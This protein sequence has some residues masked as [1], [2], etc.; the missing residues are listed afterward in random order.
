MLTKQ[1]CLP[2]AT[3]GVNNV[4]LDYEAQ[5]ARR[6]SEVNGKRLDSSCIASSLALALLVFQ[7]LTAGA[8]ADDAGASPSSRLLLAQ[9]S[10]RGGTGEG[11][12]QVLR[13]PVQLPDFP[14]YSGKAT[15]NGGLMYPNKR[16]G[17]AI[18]LRYSA[19]EDPESILGWYEDALKSYKW[20]VNRQR[21]VV[22]GSVTATKGGS[23]CVVQAA[24]SRKPGFGTELYINF[25]WAR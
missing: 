18:G 5:M 17:P 4:G 1:A 6:Y 9:A 7:A 16:G 13:E 10:D 25:K 12:W 24:P 14:A 2:V 23:S 15:F 20:A 22:P 8:R 11:A 3:F 19:R 21:G